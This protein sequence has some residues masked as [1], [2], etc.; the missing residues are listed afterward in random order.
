MWKPSNRAGGEAILRER[1]GFW[2]RLEFSY[3]PMGRRRFSIAMKNDRDDR[4]EIGN[5]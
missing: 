2:L 4:V 5:V 1:L 3:F